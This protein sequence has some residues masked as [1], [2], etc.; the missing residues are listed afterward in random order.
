[1]HNVRVKGI[2]YPMDVC[3]LYGY[4][5]WTGFFSVP[6]IPCFPLFLDSTLIVWMFVEVIRIYFF[7]GFR[8]LL[9]MLR[10][11]FIHSWK[12]NYISWRPLS[13]GWIL[14]LIQCIFNS[15]TLRY[16][17]L[18]LFLSFC[19][20]YCSVNWIYS[21]RHIYNS[22]PFFLVHLL[23]CRLLFS[24]DTQNT[25]DKKCISSIAL[26]W[27]QC[28]GSPIE[29]EIYTFRILYYSLLPIVVK[30]S[31]SLWD[32]GWTREREREP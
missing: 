19:I 5:S 31:I 27:V 13:K 6:F 24:H 2:Q 23:T 9:F 20:H 17:S 22:V 21:G 12:Y 1:M 8:M 18:L 10:T 15:S 11:L 4:C 29:H 3:N 32:C 14:K 28:I 30:F 7:F 16:D 26:T 25:R